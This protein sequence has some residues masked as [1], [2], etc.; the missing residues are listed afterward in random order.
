MLLTSIYDVLVLQ[1][2]MISTLNCDTS[3]VDATEAIID[4]GTTTCV[5]SRNKFLNVLINNLLEI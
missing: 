3:D 4:S 1:M 5:V 2:N